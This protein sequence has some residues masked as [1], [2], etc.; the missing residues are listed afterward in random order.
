MAVV[1]NG[2]YAPVVLKELALGV[3]VLPVSGRVTHHGILN[4]FPNPTSGNEIN[5]RLSLG[6][7]DPVS[8]QLW[9]MYGNSS[10]TEL[11]V[12]GN[13]ELQLPTISAASFMPGV[14]YYLIRM[15]AEVH[16]GYFV[17]I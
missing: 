5:F 1:G 6:A 11:G 4:V 10:Y 16:S 13:G 17:K 8:V 2:K 9:D 7:S 3:E 12:V 15:G 14:V